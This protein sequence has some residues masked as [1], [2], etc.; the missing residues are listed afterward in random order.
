MIDDKV[1]VELVNKIL[2]DEVLD[3]ANVNST[4]QFMLEKEESQIKV[5]HLAFLFAYFEARTNLLKINFGEEYGT[6]IDIYH[7]LRE[8]F[9]V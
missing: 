3:I 5:E 6:I 7:K 8:Q 1:F 4:L 2:H 9:N